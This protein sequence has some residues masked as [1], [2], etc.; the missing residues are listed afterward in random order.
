MRLAML[1]TLLSAP[2]S[3]TAADRS[4]DAIAAATAKIDRLLSESWQRDGIKPVERSAD[5]E[6]CRRVWLDLAGVAPPVAEV[7]RFLADGSGDK[8]ARLID[9]LLGSTQH[10]RHMA[11]RWI[12]I[13]VPADRQSDPQARQSIAALHGWLQRQFLENTPYDYF[14]GGFLTAG[15]DGNSGP[16]VFYTSYELEPKK[17]AAATSRIFMGIQLQCAECHNHPNDR[18]TQEDFWQYAAF[19]S[20]L[21]EVDGR[22]AGEVLIEDSSSGEVT[23]P[24]TDIVMSPR[25]PGIS[26][27]PERDPT[28]HRRRQLTIWMASRDNPYFARAAVNRVWAH[29]F[30]RGLVEPVDAMDA[31]NPPSHPE[32][33]EFLSEFLVEQRFDLRALYTAVANS[34]A[35]QKTSRVP[36]DLRPPQDSFAAMSV[37]TLTAQQYIDSLQQN[38]FRSG[39]ILPGEPM[40]SEQSRR[41]EFLSRMRAPESTPL[42]Y[43]HGIVQALGLMNGP[44]VAAASDENQSPLLAALRAPFFE[45]RTQVETLFLSTVSRLPTDSERERFESHLAAAETTEQHDAALADLLWVLLNTAECTVSP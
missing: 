17:V 39:V 18:W 26:E 21:K 32:L 36:A 9:R 30:G 34:E 1:L 3:V 28:G 38:V 37:K 29:L 24:E 11:S 25:Y 40:S 7:R 31:D 4:P 22:M 15:G 8:R 20:Q 14:V 27:P 16:A 19:F 42:D 43:P 45:P 12:D 10:A 33:L 23:L 13:L 44:E 2:I 41:D 5:A 6:F 35:Y